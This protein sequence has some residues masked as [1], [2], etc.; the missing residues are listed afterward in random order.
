MLPP[1]GGPDGAGLLG[2][3]GFGIG[4]LLSSRKT[5]TSPRCDEEVRS[6]RWIPVL[7]AAARACRPLLER[8]VDERVFPGAV[9]AVAADDGEP[10]VAAVG[11]LAYGDDADPVTPETLYDLASVTKLIAASGVA[12]TTVADGTITLQTRV[13][14]LVA[15]WSGDDK[16]RVTVGQLL[17]HTSGLPAHAPFYLECADGDSVRAAV[18]A[19]P[20]VARPGERCIYSDLGFILLGEVLEGAT[21]TPFEAL[22]RERVLEP[23]GLEETMFVPSAEVRRRVAPT[24]DDAWRG[25]VMRGAVHDENAYAMGGV[26]PHAGLFAT[27]G[28]VARFGRSLLRGAGRRFVSDD[29]VRQFV[30]PASPLPGTWCYGFRILGGDP[31]FGSAVSA[32]SFGGTGFTGTLL[33][34]DP[35]RDV[36][37]AFLSNSV[38]P[39]RSNRGAIPARGLVL[40]RILRAF[41]V[42]EA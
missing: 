28:D 12:M 2:P 6:W 22:V 8:L 41:D 18:R 33:A 35:D 42:E 34:V 1:G 13:G 10:A 9:A 7:S 26:A 29:V 39:T 19:S 23:L 4:D 16:D 31:A 32:A 37:V 25:E 27:A 5:R 20:L 17:S 21:R 38:H 40:D 15:D 36:A 11:A 14:D 3:Y 30:A 24:E